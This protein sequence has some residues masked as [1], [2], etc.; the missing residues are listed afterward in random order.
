MDK[1]TQTPRASPRPK[2]TVQPWRYLQTE[3]GLW[4][5]GGCFATAL[6]AAPAELHLIFIFLVQKVMLEDWRGFR[7]NR[8][9]LKEL[10]LSPE[11]RGQGTSQEKNL[12][13]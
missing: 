5:E 8:N 3:N 4:K 12:R 1:Q 7:E 9:R 11:C 10:K 6:K 2:K 13:G